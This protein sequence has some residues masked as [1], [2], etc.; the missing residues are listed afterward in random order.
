[1]E[2]KDYQPNIEVNQRIFFRGLGTTYKVL[3]TSVNGSAAIV[4]HTVEPKSIGA[5]MH[6]HT[7]EDEISY[8]LEGQLSVI[9]NGHVQTAGPGQFIAKPRGIF[10]TFWNSGEQRIRFLEVIVP[11][12]FENYFAELGLLL[13]P[14]K[15]AQL[16]KVRET[17]ARYGL[18]VDPAATEEIVKRYGLKPLA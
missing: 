2:I 6:K 17:G 5:P 11:G 8:V 10:H 7:Y 14:G 18:M 12:N 4:E 9:Q 16:D 15:P 1:M 13:A 3:S